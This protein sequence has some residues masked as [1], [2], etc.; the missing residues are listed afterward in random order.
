MSIDL[1]TLKS[2]LAGAVGRLETALVQG[3]SWTS[4][5]AALKRFVEEG[6]DTGVTAALAATPLSPLTP[7]LLP[8]VNQA[9]EAEMTALQGRLADLA[10]LK[11]QLPAGAAA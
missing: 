10:A 8:F 1:T 9:L 2:D 4:E 7:A 6:L 3:V 5:I 11:A